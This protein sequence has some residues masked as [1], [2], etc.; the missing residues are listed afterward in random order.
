MSKENELT[1]NE[2]LD[3]LKGLI[4]ALRDISFGARGEGFGALESIAVSLAGHGLHKPIGEALENIADAIN[5]HS[6]SLDNFADVIS[7]LLLN[8]Q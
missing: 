7:E 5:N 6:Q 3:L 2:K 4:S 8:N 1:K